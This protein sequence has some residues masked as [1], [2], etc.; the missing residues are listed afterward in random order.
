[1]KQKKCYIGVYVTQE[2]KDMLNDAASKAQ[3]SVSELIKRSVLL[4]AAGG[5]ETALADVMT[6][7]QMADYLHVSERCARKLCES[8]KVPS[9]T[10][11]KQHRV[12]K[13]SLDE[14]ITKTRRPTEGLPELLRPE[15]AAYYLNVSRATVRNMITSGQIAACRVAKS[16]RI[17]REDI[18]HLVNER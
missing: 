8:G 16:Y 18:L 13:A 4:P 14:Y 9:F 2:E 6:I 11:G 3:I 12:T 5:E 17:K 7:K 15:Q 10:I 1:M